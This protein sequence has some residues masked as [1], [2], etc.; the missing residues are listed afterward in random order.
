MTL[1]STDVSAASA[2]HSHVAANITDLT[3]VANVV[4]VNGR[5]GAVVLTSTNVSAASAS[6]SHVAA[7]V[8]DLTSVANVVSVNGITGTPSIV[9]GAN[10]TVSTAGSSITI[11]GAGNVA[12]VNGK[13][14]TV[15][16]TSVDVSAASASHSHVAANITDLTS[17]AN[18]VSV[19]GRT[20]TVVLTSTDV[21]AASASHSH[22]AANITDLTAVANVVSVNGKTGAVSLVAADVTAAS[23]AH[24]H[25]YVTSL[26]GG[27]GAIT[28]V[29]GSNVTVTT[30]ASS[31][32]I[33]AAAGAG[34]GGGGEYTLPTASDT[35]LGGVKV[36]SGLSISDGVLA[37]TG[38]G[39]GGGSFSWSSVPASP[40]TSGSNGDLAY[41]AFFFYVKSS[42]GW[43]RTAISAW[44]PL[45]APTSVTAVGGDAQ[46][47]VS[48]TA[49]TET[50]GYAITDYAVQYSSDSGSSWTTFSDG[51]S[52]DAS[53]VVTSLTNGTAY[54]F[55]VAAIT[56]A[57]TGPY[58]SASDSV[59]PGAASDP[60]FSNVV[61]LLHGETLVD[62]SGA[63]RTLTASGA[64]ISTAQ[65]K[66]GSSSIAIGSG[67]YVSLPG[68]TAFN[69]SGDFTLEWFHYLTSA[70]AQGWIIGGNA[71][72]NGYLML[73][74]NLSGSQQ[75]WLGGA[76]TNWP[77]QFGSV[78]LAAN[79]WQHV[80]ISRSGSSNRLYIDGTLVGSAITDSTSWVANPTQI[81]IGSQAAGTSMQGYLDEF[82]WT[83]GTA[84]G[85]TG[86][87]ITVPTAAYPE[88]AAGSDPFFSSVSLLLHADGS[89]STFV[90]SSGTP[91]T[92]TANANATQSAA[93]S[94]WGGKSAFF[95]GTGD[96]LIVPD[97]A[98]IELGNS[99]F[100]AEMWINT[101][102]SAQYS[103]LLSRSTGSFAA[104]M[105]S[106]MMNHD[107]ST[108]GDLALYVFDA[109]GGQAPLLLG[110]S[111][112]R[113]GAWHHIAI[114]R[115]GTSW[116]MYVDGTRVAT[117]TNSATI[118]NIAGDINIGRDQFYGRQYVG[119]ID[120]LRITVGTAR[121]TG[122]TLTVPTAA[123]PDS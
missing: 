104:G 76:N 35:V 91:K 96:Y 86:S 23:A 42:A 79:T 119:Y 110:G 26:N 48:W 65:K 2:S 108:A 97:A 11:A 5:T 47:T 70:T 75:L 66:F 40:S 122:S 28:I 89:G 95:N 17:V 25:S 61:L 111:G 69:M 21:S 103:T 67:Q 14:G 13:T 57:G 36:G 92:I 106:L 77:V 117:A 84:R 43:R 15:S 31:I 68:A 27:T 9:A 19:N 56:A 44:T 12:S 64:S 1:V 98:A 93:Q 30:A 109:N 41:D 94:K 52:T 113:D 55:R 121:Y 24:G 71:N 18:V 39:G 8:T 112:L 87:T 32:T 16:L 114:S 49:P 63:A 29:A 59:T 22:V 46:A 81:W 34:G 33:A 45:G 10:V 118:S 107:S 85:Y 73:G 101:T 4:S 100:A 20:G 51:T 82:R 105:W 99:D 58:S 60:F 80:A 102:N 38:G 74:I 6:H 116:G 88:A 7:N 62:S 37:A 53:A 72:A 83:V 3:S 120:D 78:P 54:T 115:S 50:G 90:D 123:F